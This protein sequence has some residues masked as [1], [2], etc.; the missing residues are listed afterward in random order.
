MRIINKLCDN[1][2]QRLVNKMKQYQNNFICYLLLILLFSGCEAKEQQSEKNIV[3]V[4]GLKF[5]YKIEGSGIT[6]MVIGSAIQQPRMF[7]QELRKQ[8]KFI[9]IDSRLF[10]P[11]RI[12][13]FTLDDA[14]EDIEGI[15]KYLNIGKMVVMGN[16][17]F[18]IIALEYAKKY[19][20][21]N[22]ACFTSFGAVL[23]LE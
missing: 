18:A 13:K 3:S 4:N 10:I 16:S 12:E 2:S 15:R 6:T 5:Q 17:M 22:H 20:N 1:N 11:A 8:F 14:V 21:D 7:S 19:P 23:F 9:F